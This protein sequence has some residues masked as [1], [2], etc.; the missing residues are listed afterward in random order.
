MLRHNDEDLFQDT[1]MTFGEHLEELRGSL[2]KAVLALVL[3]FGIGLALGKPVVQ[4]IQ[5]PL[6]AALFEFYTD[7]AANRLW[8]D[9]EQRKKANLP[10]PEDITDLKAAKRYVK[11]ARLL[12]DG[13]IFAPIEPLLDQLRDQF[14]A[15]S[16]N[17]PAAKKSASALLPDR[18]NMLRI[19][20]WRQAEEDRRLRLVTFN[21]QEGFMIYIKASFIAG[22]VLSSPFVFYFLW[23]FVAAGLYPHEKKY[24]HIFLPFSVGL[25][26]MGA[27][28]AF[29]FVFPPVLNFFFSF[30]DWIDSDME[31]RLSEWLSFV[32]MMPLAF[33]ISFQLPLAMLFLERIGIFTAASYISKWRIAVL[34]MA[35]LSM[36]L[37]PG[38]DPYSMLFMLVPLVVLYFG[39]IALCKY[40]P[41]GH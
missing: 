29:F 2:F 15:L 26:L 6:Q 41:R 7:K 12:F 13:T 35:V 10:V 4:L 20:M 28:M 1:T 33:G 18:K 16:R 25:F 3:G 40:M 9:I 36:V 14:P 32:L 31:P 8:T 27:A 37:S 21:S 39:G 11:E 30:N 38:G 34:I 23:S 24:V 5:H 22:A 19:D 17:L